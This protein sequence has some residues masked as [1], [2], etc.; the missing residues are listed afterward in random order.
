MIL[1]LGNHESCSEQSELLRHRAALW[2]GGNGPLEDKPKVLSAVKMAP[3]GGQLP[4]NLRAE[5]QACVKTKGSL[6][7]LPG[8]LC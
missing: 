5:F 2:C 4:Q 1:G 6:R 7:F 3:R 8:L